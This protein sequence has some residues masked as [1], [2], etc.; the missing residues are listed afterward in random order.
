MYFSPNLHGQGNIQA[1]RSYFS[2]PGYVVLRLCQTYPPLLWQFL[3]SGCLR[4]SAFIEQSSHGSDFHLRLIWPEFEL[5]FIDKCFNVLF[6]ITWA[7]QL[8]WVSLVREEKKERLY[9]AFVW[10]GKG[11]LADDKQSH[12]FQ[13]FGA[14]LK[15]VGIH[16]E[17]LW[18]LYGCNIQWIQRD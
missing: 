3:W 8:L 4:T 17:F 16:H 13:C 10:L 9:F 18:F 7:F 5:C 2:Y 12:S 11:I 1:A 6:P 15:P 14:S